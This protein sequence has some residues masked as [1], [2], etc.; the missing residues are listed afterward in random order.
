M[1]QSV[2]AALSGERLDRA[3][4]LLWETSRAGAAELVAAGAVQ[5][6]GL[7]RTVRS[8]RLAAG[9]ELIVDV[10]ALASQRQT[11]R[12]QPEPE[13]EPK[14]VYADLHVVV[15]DKPAGLVVH[16]GAG[17]SAGTLCGGLLARYPEMATVGEPARPGIV[18]RLDAGTSGL[19]VAAR[20]ALAYDSLVAQLAARTVE[21]CYEAICLGLMAN[22]GALSTPRL[23]AL[24]GGVGR[25]RSASEG[26]RP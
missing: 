11:G 19:L 21:R 12:P 2:P 5:V 6:N 23:A 8:A 25:W 14:L 1:I 22:D 18:H 13:V 10:E 3:V 15:V 4:A 17:R 9:D 24:V 20:T 7:V 16:P 26:A